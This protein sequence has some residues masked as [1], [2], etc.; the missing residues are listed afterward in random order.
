MAGYDLELSTDA[1]F[2]EESRDFLRFL[3]I[4]ARKHR[5]QFKYRSLKQ[6]SYYIAIDGTPGARIDAFFQELVL[7][8]GL[9]YYSCSMRSRELVTSK[10]IAPA[11]RQLLESRFTIIPSRGLSKH[12]LGKASDPFFPGDLVDAHAHS[13]ES[14]FLKWNLDLIS[15]YEFVKDADDLLTN[16]MLTKMEYTKGLKSPAF[17]RLVDRFRGSNFL[18]G[19]RSASS[20]KKIHELR[21]RGLHRME[22]EF[23]KSEISSLALEVYF[24]FEYFD[25]F[26]E[27]QKVKTIVIRGKRYRR[28]KY[29][30]EVWL[31]ERGER[32]FDEEGNPYRFSTPLCHDCEAGTGQYHLFGCDAEICPA[33]GTQAISCDCEYEE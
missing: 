5:V 6:G 1:R 33:C 25:E 18:L 26:Q 21:T 19:D 13:Y 16:F 31:N 3:Q 15:D 28:I 7:N 20:F 17:N 11:F 29:G 9:Y 12:I 30:D 27:C 10:V 4:V 8:K 22:R 2:H 32:L 14:L 24:Y 23:D